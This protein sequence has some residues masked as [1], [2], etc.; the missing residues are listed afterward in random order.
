MP[1]PNAQKVIV[2]LRQVGLKR[3]L[4]GVSQERSHRIFVDPTRIVADQAGESIFGQNRLNSRP[5]GDH[6]SHQS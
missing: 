6:Q 3:I 1:L 4:P 2:A 5:F